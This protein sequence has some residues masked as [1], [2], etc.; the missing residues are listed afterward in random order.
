MRARASGPARR[1][2]RARDAAPLSPS[3]VRILA[4]YREG[5]IASPPGPKAAADLLGIKRQIAAGLV[6]HLVARGS[7]VRLPGDWIVA[8]EAVEEAAARLRASGLET[9]DVAAFKTLF[10]LTRKIG[11]PLLDHLAATGVVRREGSVNRVVRP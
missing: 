11:I 4:L 1:G 10:G 5:G 2:T 3:A 7:L 9:I 6:E 8:S